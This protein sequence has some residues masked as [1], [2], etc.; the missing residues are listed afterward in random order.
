MNHGM[1]TSPEQKLYKAPFKLTVYY[2]E[3]CQ[4]SQLV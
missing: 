4:A 2:S 3:P 1:T